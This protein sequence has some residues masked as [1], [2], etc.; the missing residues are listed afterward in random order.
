MKLAMYLQNSTMLPCMDDL[1]R[2]IL[3]RSRTHID[4]MLLRCIHL[5]NADQPGTDCTDLC[6]V[7]RD[8]TRNILQPY[9]RIR[10]L[11]KSSGCMLLQ[12]RKDLQ[13]TD[14]LCI[15]FRSRIF[16]LRRDHCGRRGHSFRCLWDGNLCI[17][18]R[19]IQ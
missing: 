15:H 5:L 3:L 8:H 18:C 19:N 17:R 1:S 11:R 13:S 10:S 6:I 9:I 14:L 7:I 16:L 12:C 2:R 4:S